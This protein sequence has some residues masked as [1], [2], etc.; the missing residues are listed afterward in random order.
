[1][2]FAAKSIN[3]V[4]FSRKQHILLQLP[5]EVVLLSVKL[6]TAQSSERLQQDPDTLL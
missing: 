5:F 3:L 6:Y 4:A 2:L 1:M